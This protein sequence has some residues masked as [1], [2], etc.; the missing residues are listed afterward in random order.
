MQQQLIEDAFQAQVSG[1]PTLQ[2]ATL[3]RRRDADVNDGGIQTHRIYRCANGSYA[4]FICT[5]G[6]DGYLT[7]LDERRAKNALRSTPELYRVEFGCEP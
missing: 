3:V 1:S 5:A 6:E 2:G 4:L 7:F